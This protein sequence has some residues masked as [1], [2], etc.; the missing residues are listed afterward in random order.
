LENLV[1]AEHA[2]LTV[3]HQDLVVV[4]VKETV[5]ARQGSLERLVTANLAL[6]LAKTVVAVLVMEPAH[7]LLAMAVLL[8]NLNS[9]AKIVSMET[10]T[11]R[12]ERVLVMLVSL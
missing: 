11:L 12:L 6:P 9:A 2:K 8:V 1:L 3:L 5:F 7:V 4:T 10:V